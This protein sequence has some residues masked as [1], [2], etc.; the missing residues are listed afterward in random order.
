MIYIRS[1]HLISPL[2]Q[3]ISLWSSIVLPAPVTALVPVCS[4]SVAKSCLTLLT[5]WTV[6]HQ[7][8]LSMDSP[9]ESTGVGC[10][11]LPQEILQTQ[12][13]PASLRSPALAG[14]VFT[15]S[16]TWEAPANKWLKLNYRTCPGCLVRAFLAQEQGR[17]WSGRPSF[18]TS[19][20]D[21]ERLT[22][23]FSLP[24]SQPVPWATSSTRHQGQ[25]L[26]NY[27]PCVPPTSGP[28][29]GMVGFRTTASRTGPWLLGARLAP[30]PGSLD[31][32]PDLSE[33]LS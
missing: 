19:Q 28:L 16:V 8:P 14:G 22:V 3:D 15:T 5:P 26:S 33:E 30:Q 23:V 27:L 10:H 24:P 9:G 6:A 21:A 2:G 20:G 18:R 11:A 29:G 1:H 13:G 31:F 32:S 25:L 17:D 4:C 7:A 12:D